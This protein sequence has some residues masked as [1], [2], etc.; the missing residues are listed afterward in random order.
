MF[1][2]CAKKNSKQ[3]IFLWSVVQLSKR[4]SYNFYLLYDVLIIVIY[5]MEFLCTSTPNKDLNLWILIKKSGCY[6]LKTK[7]RDEN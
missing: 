4:R 7:F 6:L 1:Y 3:L 5:N 2:D